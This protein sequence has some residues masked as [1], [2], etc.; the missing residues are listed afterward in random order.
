MALSGEATS[1]VPSSEI[2]V[3]QVMNERVKII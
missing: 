1:T 2:K 3:D